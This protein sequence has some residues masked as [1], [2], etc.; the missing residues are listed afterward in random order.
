MPRFWSPY[1]PELRPWAYRTSYLLEDLATR[2]DVS[3][4][5]AGRFYALGPQL[6][7]TA[8]GVD[9]E[10]R[11]LQDVFA[12]QQEGE[13]LQLIRAEAAHLAPPDEDG[14]QVVEF[15]RGEMLTLRDGRQQGDRRQRFESL[16]YR[17]RYGAVL[18]RPDHRRAQAT[19]ALQLSPAPKDRAEF[20]WRVTMP[21]LAFTMT[22]LA[23]ALG[24]RP[25]AGRALAHGCRGGT[26]CR[27][28]LFGGSRSNGARERVARRIPW[29]LWPALL[30]L[31]AAV[32]VAFPWAAPRMRGFTKA[33]R[34]LAL[35]VLKGYG[36]GD[37]RAPGAVLPLCL[38][39]RS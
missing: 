18:G 31:L 15:Q 38:P 27:R 34:Y 1:S 8:S 21:L 3:T 33:D 25:A 10:G 19:A 28:V 39:R 16:T 29:A 30:P 7:V 11:T 13:A 14:V 23:A 35:A 9:G 26:L 37:H 6:V 5:R 17:W 12:R 4:M 20:Q 24:V 22:V 32:V 2:P 36:T